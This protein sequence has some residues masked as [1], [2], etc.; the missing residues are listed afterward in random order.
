M[1][2]LPQSKRRVLKRTS[3]HKETVSKGKKGERLLSTE[4]GDE[5]I[6]VAEG[7]RKR[8]ALLRCCRL[9][10]A[11]GSRSGLEKSCNSK[12]SKL[13]D[14]AGVTQQQPFTLL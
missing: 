1:H 10:K 4:R 2:N 6:N 8:V 7:D 3:R 9:R 5:E 13:T 12:A 14:A 11:D